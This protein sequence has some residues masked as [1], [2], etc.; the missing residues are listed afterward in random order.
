MEQQKKLSEDLQA[1]IRET[2]QII[3]K[4]A[5]VMGEMDGISFYDVK[6]LPLPKD[7]IAKALLLAIKLTGDEHQRESLKVA[8]N[9]LA[10]FQEGVGDNHIRPSPVLPNGDQ[11]TPEELVKLFA[12]HRPESERF[13]QFQERAQAEEQ[14]YA[15]MVERL[16]KL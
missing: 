12:D 7:I 4:Y 3:G 2:Q 9:I 5:K 11:T 1:E 8:L 13:S 15:D 16:L 6:A 10:R 14:A